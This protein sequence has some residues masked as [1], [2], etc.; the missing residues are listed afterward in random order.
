MNRPSV[1]RVF[2]G[3]AAAGLLAA[4]AAPARASGFPLADVSRL[5]DLWS[6]AW[7]WMVDVWPGSDGSAGVAASRTYNKDNQ[8]PPPGP[9]PPKPKPPAQTNGGGHG[10]GDSGP[11]S[12]P[13]G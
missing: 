1:R 2:V 7:S 6:H 13:D 3:L 11:G 12:D 5:Q 8:G 9:P 10:G 4:A